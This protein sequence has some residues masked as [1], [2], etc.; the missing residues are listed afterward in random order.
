MFVALKLYFLCNFD[1][2]NSRKVVHSRVSFIT[3]IINSRYFN[4]FEM[5]N[6]QYIANLIAKLIVFTYK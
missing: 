2:N 1:M 6:M 3:F 4:R 5:L